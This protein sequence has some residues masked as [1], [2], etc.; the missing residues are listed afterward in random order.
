[1][2]QSAK[3]QILLI[4]FSRGG[5]TRKI[6]EAMAARL[7]ALGHECTLMSVA[8]ALAAEPDWQRFDV[9]AL[10]ACVLY[11][12]YHKSVFEL[13]NRYQAALASRPS[14]FYCINVVARNP[15]KR[16]LENNKYLQKFLSL[17]P[18]QPQDLKI[19]AGKVDYPSWPWYDALMIRLIMKMTNGPT[20][21]KAVIDYTDWQ[22][23]DKYAEHLLTL[24]Q[25][26]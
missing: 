26:H 21:P 12:T 25:A 1:M 19:I 23:V 15:E 6:S 24:A 3:R 17:S 8:E 2:S 5:H 18:W 9:V 10:G 7:N 22:D 20:D 14:S 16:V 4:Y 13:V 11:G